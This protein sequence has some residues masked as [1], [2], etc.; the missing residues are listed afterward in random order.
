[1]GLD[2][3]LNASRFL[4]DLGDDPDVK[5][6][7]DIGAMFPELKGKRAREVSTELFYWRKANAIHKWFVD[8][9][10]EGRDDCGYYPVELEQLATLRDLCRLVLGNPDSASRLL[11]TQGGFFFGGTD[12]DEYYFQD[13]E[14]T[15]QFLD[16]F[17]PE[18][19]D[20]ASSPWRR[21]QIEYHSSW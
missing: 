6:A 16:E 15:V 12:Y 19:T 18:Y 11:P 3:Y 17:L 5:L 21:W 13:L 8:T 1:M 20:D 2:M 10:Q 7:V 4:W 14:R 9:V